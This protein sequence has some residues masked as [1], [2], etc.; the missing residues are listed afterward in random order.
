MFFLRIFD[1]LAGFVSLV[2]GVITE[3]M[4]FMIFYVILIFKFSLMIGVLGF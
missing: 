1:F 2:K 4:P 3:L